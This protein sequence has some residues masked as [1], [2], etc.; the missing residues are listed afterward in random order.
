MNILCA[1]TWLE[2]IEVPL[3]LVEWTLIT[4]DPFFLLCHSLCLHPRNLSPPSL[5]L[6]LS[7]P[8]RVLNPFDI[9]FGV[10][11]AW[12][13]S[14]LSTLLSLSPS[15][16]SGFANPLTS[17]LEKGC[18]DLYLAGHCSQARGLTLH[19]SLSLPLPRPSRVL[20]IH[21]HHFW[22]RDVQ[23]CT[24]QATVRRRGA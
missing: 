12:A 20:L 3:P 16:K 19:P 23:I 18:T 24:W 6:S 11:A 22:R 10:G 15:A 8:T 21:W 5:S 4:L 1:T 2:A 17:L 14:K 7:R 13:E 9:T